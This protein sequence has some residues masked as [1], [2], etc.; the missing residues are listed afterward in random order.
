[1]RHLP[2]IYQKIIENDLTKHENNL[3]DIMINRVDFTKKIDL[4][5]EVNKFKMVLIKNL[6]S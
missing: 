5:E 4:V 2:V 1:M 6:E 3:V